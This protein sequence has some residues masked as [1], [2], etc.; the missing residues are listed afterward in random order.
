MLRVY[1]R[2][3]LTYKDGSRA[4]RVNEMTVLTLK[5]AN[6]WSQIKQI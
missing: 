2:Q 4:E 3:I 6:V 1:R 5:Y